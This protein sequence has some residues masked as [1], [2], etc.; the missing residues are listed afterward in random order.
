VE[1]YSCLPAGASHVNSREAS[2]IDLPAGQNYRIERKIK[3]VVAAIWQDQPAIGSSE[4]GS[5]TRRIEVTFALASGFG[6][7]AR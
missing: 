3:N 1:Q 4:V 2:N 6:S 7:M 5:P